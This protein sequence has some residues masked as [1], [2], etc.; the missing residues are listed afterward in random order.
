MAILAV[1]PRPKKKR[2][3]GNKAV[4]G[5]ER[6]KSIVG[7]VASASFGMRPIRSPRGTPRIAATA[8]PTSERTTVA[9]KSLANAPCAKLVQRLRAT[10]HGGGRNNGSTIFQAEATLHSAT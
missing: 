8:K 7:W 6:Q 9:I 1:S 10:A 5:T 3:S 4:A 2:K